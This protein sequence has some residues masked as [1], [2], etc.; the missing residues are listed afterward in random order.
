MTIYLICSQE[1]ALW[2]GKS[3][4]DG[5]GGMRSPFPHSDSEKN[6]QTK[7][8][9]P[10]VSSEAL[11]ATNST[12][13][14]NQSKIQR[15]IRALLTSTPNQHVQQGQVHRGAPRSKISPRSPSPKLWLNSHLRPASLLG[16][17]TAMQAGAWAPHR[18]CSLLMGALA[19]GLPQTQA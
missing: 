10:L 5:C 15:I 2:L 18:N 3:F 9:R 7:K 11:W 1:A 13:L 17:Q 12:R 8:N 14:Q 4:Q 19:Y 16:Q 6:K